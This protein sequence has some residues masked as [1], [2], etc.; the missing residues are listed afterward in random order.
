MGDPRFLLAEE[1]PIPPGASAFRVRGEIYRNSID[2]LGSIVPGGI[3]GIFQELH[4]SRL[5]IFLSKQFLPASWYDALPLQWQMTAAARASGKP[6]TQVARDAMR[7]QAKRDV[8]V[9]H[10]LLWKLDSVE[11]VITRLPRLSTEYFDFI[12]STSTLRAPGH[13][14]LICRGV[15]GVIVPWYCAAMDGFLSVALESVGG[16]DVRIRAGRPEWD[17]ESGGL[18]TNRVSFDI[19]WR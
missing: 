12:K 17:G 16:K 7:A 4:D 15:P 6:F 18:V 3:D 11:Q 2:Y 13:A 9:P 14:T 8:N 1:M 5:R 10:R 19:R